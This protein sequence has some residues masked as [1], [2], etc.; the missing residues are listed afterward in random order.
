MEFIGLSN[1]GYPMAMNLR[2][3]LPAFRR[4]IILDVNDDAMKRFAAEAKNMAQSSGAAVDT[5]RV[6]MSNNA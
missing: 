1:I 2:E 4:L 3:K 5:M 6:E